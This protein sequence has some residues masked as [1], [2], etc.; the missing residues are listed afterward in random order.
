MNSKCFQA[1]RYVDIPELFME[2]EED[3]C[4]MAEFPDL[5]YEINDKLEWVDE[6]P[7]SIRI[8]ENIY[9]LQEASTDDCLLEDSD[10]PYYS[11]LEE[12]PDDPIVEVQQG[13]RDHTQPIETTNEEQIGLGKEESLPSVSSSRSNSDIEEWIESQDSESSFEIELKPKCGRGRRAQPKC[14]IVRKKKEEYKNKSY[15]YQKSF[16]VYQ[17]LIAGLKNSI[18]GT[19]DDKK[20]SERG[21]PRKEII[22]NNQELTRVLKIWVQDLDKKIGKCSPKGRTDA[23]DVTIK[24][25]ICKISDVLLKYIS[26]KSQYKSKDLKISLHAYI[27]TFVKGFAPIFNYSLPKNFDEGSKE[28]EKLISDFFDFCIL[29]FPKDRVKKLLEMYRDSSFPSIDISSKLDEIEEIG[30]T[31][32]VSFKKLYEANVSLQFICKHL[33]TI[34]SLI[35]MKHEDCVHTTLNKI[36]KS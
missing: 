33:N 13:T 1:I 3:I 34:L 17:E 26:T 20:K 19:I 36:I 9:E 5:S 11:V 27:E 14:K 10:T 6:A 28:E 30:G 25:K 35:K 18:N 7:E 8:N 29:S 15:L 22:I 21:R 12:L 24:R 31:S 2:Y 4:E 16:D 23:L 32:L